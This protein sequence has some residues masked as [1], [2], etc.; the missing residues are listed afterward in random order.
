MSWNG[1]A[2]DARP[3]DHANGSPIRDPHKGLLNCDLVMKGGITSGVVYPKAVVRLARRYRI[4]SIGGPSVGAIAAALTAAAEY[5]RQTHAGQQPA[6]DER[7]AAV[8]EAM[9]EA[10]WDSADPKVKQA[11]ARLTGTGNPDRA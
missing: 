11:E 7:I 6:Q 3:L 4:R 1:T 10:G 5:W 9:E 2:M 8:I